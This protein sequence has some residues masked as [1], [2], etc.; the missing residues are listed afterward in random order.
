MDTGINYD[1]LR[2]LHEPK[3]TPSKLF[4]LTQSMNQLEDL[5]HPQIHGR[6]I[7][8]YA[9]SFH[10]FRPSRG[11][12]DPSRRPP[13][14]PALQRFQKPQNQKQA[15]LQ[16]QLQKPASRPFFSLLQST[17]LPPAQDSAQNVYDSSNRSLKLEELS[18]RSPSSPPPQSSSNAHIPTQDDQ[19]QPR[20][21]LPPRSPPVGP[22]SRSGSRE[23]SRSRSI[24]NHSHERPINPNIDGGFV[25]SRESSTDLPDIA[26]KALKEVQALHIELAEERRRTKGLQAQ[27]TALNSAHESLKLQHES[28]QQDIVSF[29]Q[30]SVEQG[31]KLSDIRDELKAACDTLHSTQGALAS[32]QQELVTANADR[33]S[34]Q[35]KLAVEEERTKTKL[36]RIKKGVGELGENYSTLLASFQDLKVSYDSSQKL[37]TEL[38]EARKWAADRLQVLEPLLNDEGRYGRAAEVKVL[39]G[40]LQEELQNS[41]RVVDLLR[42][43]LHHVSTQLA[44]AQGRVRELEGN[45]RSTL[46][47][48]L[49]RI[50]GENGHEN[51]PPTKQEALADKME[52][53]LERLIIRER[54]TITALAEA[55]M[56]ESRLGVAHAQIE[57]M[58]TE[59]NVLRD[60]KDAK[61]LLELRVEDLLGKTTSLEESLSR[62]TAD[63]R[64]AQTTLLQL[65]TGCAV[66]K[67]ENAALQAQL[68]DSQTSMT[69]MIQVQ[70]T[71]AKSQREAF[72]TELAGV[73]KEVMEAEEARRL[74]ELQM[75]ILQERFDA[76]AIT[77]SLTKEQ[78]GKLQVSEAALG[79]ARS[80]VKGK[81]EQ[82]AAVNEDA[83]QKSK[84]LR[85]AEIQ[86]VKLQ[87]QF[88][89]QAISLK[90]AEEHSRELQNANTKLEAALVS[91]QA[92]LADARQDLLEG[93]AALINVSLDWEKRLEQ[94]EE[95]KRLVESAE[96]RALEAD[97]TAKLVDLVEKLEQRIVRLEEE[98]SRN[99]IEGKSVEAERVRELAEQ[100]EQLKG[101]NRQLM[102]RAGNLRLRYEANDLADDERDFVDWLMKLSSSLHEQEDVA[103]DNE[104]RCRE[105]MI[106]KL[107]AKIRELE[108]TLARLLKQRDKDSG[109]TSKSMI[110]LNAW[111]TS[112]PDVSNSHVPIADPPAAANSATD[113]TMTSATAGPP[114]ITTA[115]NNAPGHCTSSGS[116]FVRGGAP[117]QDAALG[118]AAKEDPA[119]TRGV[120]KPQAPKSTVRAFDTF[121]SLG[122]SDSE[123]DIPLSEMSASV[124]GKRE[125]T[126]SP[127]KPQT[128]GSSH[129]RRLV[130]L[131]SFN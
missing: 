26:I 47:D 13:I 131:F 71:G 80:A 12:T 33:E 11:Q 55:A 15:F 36:E 34:F 97:R 93:R 79:Q 117:S 30:R 51:Q 48:S 24:P 65:E 10:A 37:I 98:K 5:N 1:A 122:E 86:L 115:D 110:D 90:K 70:A 112:S 58:D 3:S 77:R 8:G 76:Q 39:V 22:I 69:E 113:I 20:Q 95:N 38:R 83:R 104:L 130:A 4:S 119:K 40:E 118:L 114:I 94:S 82:L 85:Q 73:K 87:E 74:A 106:V 9:D 29:R 88:N 50:N 91:T 84:E 128:A 25:S 35:L 59:L 124:L 103:K 99:V 129:A 44:E 100:V 109:A 61:C 121:S 43:K 60:C 67:S 54:E 6:G 120:P 75:A 45:E 62:T 66:F 107:Q 41:H 63:L 108:S 7:V 57:A 126:A 101:V 16:P 96:K 52:S 102:E 31:H 32:S 49:R 89:A 19:P 72:D 28:S 78:S 46:L 116:A 42:D 68:L 53:L 14:F 2:G 127:P 23:R 27:M 92:A 123:D 81:T 17:T 111:M 18:E 56:L 125:R 105:N 64:A 21:M